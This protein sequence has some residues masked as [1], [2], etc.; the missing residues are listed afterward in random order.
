[1]TTDLAEE[2][3]PKAVASVRTR[4]VARLIALSVLGV[5][6]G[7]VA[8][9]QGWPDDY[10]SIF[11]WLWL[12]SVAW[13]IEAPP[14]THLAFIRDWWIPLVLLMFYFYSREFA[15]DLGIPVYY[16]Y[17][18]DFDVWFGGGD[19][20]SARLQ[21]LL[22]GSPCQPSGV[23]HWYDRVFIIVWM[24][25]FTVGL[26]MA[27]IFWFRS[28]PAFVMWMRRYLMINFAAL[29]CY[30]LI[31]TAPP[32]MASM[33]GRLPTEVVRLGAKAWVGPKPEGVGDPDPSSWAGN[34]VAAMPSL[35][36]GVAVLVAAYA[37]LQLS[38]RWRWLLILY[39][40]TMAFALVYLG[41]HYVADVLGGVVLAVAVLVGCSRWESWR[42]RRRLERPAS[43]PH[44][45]QDTSP[46]LA[47]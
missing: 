11:A 29:I 22:C 23:A 33:E 28:R 24:S 42:Q 39:P 20:P 15:D 30:V 34:A 17:A 13:R 7:L 9:D 27:V 41:E 37:I 32:W 26:T 38:S 25:H 21:E 43:A 10:V 16:Q 12:L 6:F 2:A 47:G 40:L 18:I 14:V 3:T 35:H 46:T 45:N 31:P 19:T 1:M 4:P 44:M 5:L 36:T 8:Y